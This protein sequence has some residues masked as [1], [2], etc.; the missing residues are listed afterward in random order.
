[1]KKLLI[2]MTL[3]STLTAQASCIGEYQN[4]ITD[5]DQEIT[6]RKDN[7]NIVVKTAREGGPFV[8]A[9][10]FLAGGLTGLEVAKA[11]GTSMAAGGPS[12]AASAG[13]LIVLPLSAYIIHSMSDANIEEL[14]NSR[15]A[16][17]SALATLREGVVGD[18]EHIRL[19]L[20]RAIN[21]GLNDVSLIDIA[22][23]VNELSEAKAFCQSGE[24]DNFYQV[25]EKVM[26]QLMN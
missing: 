19:I 18:G 20:N 26:N 9:A 15:S 11:A 8:G 1:M 12:T 14:Y 16:A 25:E 7:E 22:D 13:A 24:L 17:N 2:A 6:E 5:I 4:R 10:G 3:L 21:E 23:T